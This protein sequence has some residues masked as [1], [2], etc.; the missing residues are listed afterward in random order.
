MERKGDGGG[1]S[2]R[3]SEKQI[4]KDNISQNLDVTVCENTMRTLWLEG[5]VWWGEWGNGG[6]VGDGR[7][8]SRKGK[9]WGR[10]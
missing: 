1:S 8:S 10:Q 5:G 4:E 7:S 6:S 9:S 2:K 3:R